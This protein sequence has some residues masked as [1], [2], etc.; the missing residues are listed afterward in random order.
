LFA[1]LHF[2]LLFA[3][4]HFPLLFAA[5]H[6]PLLFAALTGPLGPRAG[7]SGHG[8]VLSHPCAGPIRSAS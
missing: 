1:A 6:F 3:A 2:P 4:L 5:L 8:L 7:R